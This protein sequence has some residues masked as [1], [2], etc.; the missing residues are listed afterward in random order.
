MAQRYDMLAIPIRAAGGAEAWFVIE[1]ASTEVT[2]DHCACAT[3][4]DLPKGWKGRISSSETGPAVISVQESGGEPVLRLLETQG[5]EWALAGGG[6]ETLEVTS[7]LEDKRKQRWTIRKRPGMPAE[8]QFTVINHL[9]FARL[10]IR[11]K[12]GDEVRVIPLELVSRKLDYDTEYRRMTEDIAH[13]CEQLLLTW[14]APTGLRF[15]ADTGRP[16]ALLLERFL[17]LRNF[18]TDE[19]LGRLLEVIERNPHSHLVANREWKPAGM[20]RSTDFLSNPGGMLRSWQMR[21]GRAVPCEVLDVRKDETHDTAPNRFLKFALSQFR[22]LCAEILELKG[23]AT[24]LG[25]E[26]QGLMGDLDAILARR[27]FRDIG[28]LNRLPL[29]NPTLQ[30]GE[31]YRE[32]LRAWILTEA[33]AT[34]NWAGQEESYEGSTRDVATLYEYWIFIKLHAILADF[35]GMEINPSRAA[36][37][38]RDFISKSNGEILIQLKSGQASRSSFRLR[39]SEEEFLCID[40]HYERTFSSGGAATSSWSYSR[41]FRPDYTLSMYPSRFKTE[42]EAEAA[43]KI[44]HLHF[45][46]KYRV[47]K[48]GQLFGDDRAPEDED[49]GMDDEKRVEKTES[50]YQRGDL[51]KMH[52]YND[53]LRQTIGSYVLY[54]GDDSQT[55]T[56]RKFHEIAPGVGAL[57][58]KPGNAECLRLLE[59]FLAEVFAH[60]AS[61][62]TQYRYLSD[63]RHL[64]VKHE[65]ESFRDEGKVY[66]VARKS[67]PC[68]ILW[69]KKDMEETC[70]NHGFAYC[71]AVPKPEHGDRAKIDLNLSIEIGSEFIPCGRGRAEKL[72]GMGWRG[73][74]TAARFLSKEKLRHY[75]ENKGL[76]EKLSPGSVDHYLLFE[77]NEITAMKKLDLSGVHKQYRSGS[78]YMAVTCGW[79]AIL[80]AQAADEAPA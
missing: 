41:N 32:V 39:L 59:G 6:T 62:F 12:D 31:G 40:L 75:I 17:F 2:L 7:T 26:A 49:T 5:Y 1:A 21:G 16:A 38:A 3:D 65:P 24:P 57:I 74:I 51:L 13:F 64:A 72:R 11:D 28:R 10:A 37:T 80:N 14:D 76:G 56:M 77:F 19:K 23:S 67:A 73:K 18:L 71:H 54:P 63:T 43:G 36:S 9:G 44:A 4:E 52:T 29:D 45:D 46:A 60:Q 15:S 20:A 61:Q 22:L 34:L 53:A 25:G 27:F 35:D 79:D 47:S 69:L 68:V 30:K 70:R 33:A 55:E 66:D 58:M 8:G 78:D 50:S 42:E 48:V